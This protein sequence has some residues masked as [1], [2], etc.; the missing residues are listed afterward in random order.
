MEKA[1]VVA[2]RKS[3]PRVSRAG[4]MPFPDAQ[5]PDLTVVVVVVSSCLI[6]MVMLLYC[7]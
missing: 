6:A 7:K 5:S 3:G 1:G 2:M 4:R